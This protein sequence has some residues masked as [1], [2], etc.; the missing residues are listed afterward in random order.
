MRNYPRRSFSIARISHPELPNHSP[1]PIGFTALD[2]LKRCRTFESR[3]RSFKPRTNLWSR[4]NFGECV[5]EARHL[6]DIP[7][8]CPIRRIPGEPRCHS[9]SGGSH[10]AS[11]N[12]HRDVYFAAELAGCL[13][14]AITPEKELEQN[15]F[16]FSESSGSTP[17]WYATANHR[18]LFT[19][20]LL[21]SR[22][23]SFG[24]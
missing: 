17:A 1:Q 4:N 21:C 6:R 11:E 9:P 18:S 24:G 5:E 10:E 15:V 8:I 7:L 20:S 19:R 12:I 23:L 13:F 3:V 14:A 22:S 16:A 2:Y